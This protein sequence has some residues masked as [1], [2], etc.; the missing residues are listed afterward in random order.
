MSVSMRAPTRQQLQ[1]VALADRGFSPEHIAG[2]LGLT[3]ARVN[4]HLS[5]IRSKVESGAFRPAPLPIEHAANQPLVYLAGFDVFRIDA[6]AHGAQLKALCAQHGFAGIFPLDHAAPPGLSA[7]Q[8]AQWIYQANLDAIRHAD[9][10]MANLDDFR[11]PGECD[12]GTAFEVGFASA[13]GIPVWG[14]TTDEGALLDRAQAS[15]NAQGQALCARG[16]LVEDFG[17][18]KNLMLACA[19]RLVTG[20]PHACL[21]AMAQARVHA[22]FARVEPSHR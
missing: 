2:E 3:V 18:S 7:Q 10:V 13:L 8:A 6:A 22:L 5:K 19:A 20:G 17:L 16:Y 21:A 1:I 15:R 11:G 9:V 14:Y 12:S 4:A